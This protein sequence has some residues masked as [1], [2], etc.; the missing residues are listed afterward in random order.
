[1][2]DL[3][4]R[5]DNIIA[6]YNTFQNSELLDIRGGLHG[7][8]Y[9]SAGESLR[10]QISNVEYN[11]AKDYNE[12]N[13]YKIGDLVIYDGSIYQCRINM[14]IEAGEFNYN[15]WYGPLHLTSLIKRAMHSLSPSIFSNL[16][17]YK[18]SSPYAGKQDISFNTIHSIFDLPSDVNVKIPL[19]ITSDNVSGLPIYGVYGVFT[20][21]TIN[22]DLSLLL[23][24][25]HYY[26]FDIYLSYVFLYLSIL[27][28]LPLL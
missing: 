25:Y 7:E 14:A 19:T 21:I 26:Y 18:L 2:S 6:S 22:S 8:P 27:V 3:Y 20:N 24:H 13:V 10:G 17:S 16:S 1:M 15:Y 28:F 9:R 5:T 12:Q 4:N 11:I 23:N